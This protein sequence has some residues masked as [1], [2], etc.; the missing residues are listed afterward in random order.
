MI[1]QPL[2]V[3]PHYSDFPVDSIGYGLAGG[4][5]GVYTLDGR[6]RWPDKESTSREEYE[7]WFRKLAEQ[8]YEV[9]KEYQEAYR[10]IL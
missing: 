8:G 5:I 4:G 1:E 6:F 10:S 2:M 7:Y 9:P 3:Y